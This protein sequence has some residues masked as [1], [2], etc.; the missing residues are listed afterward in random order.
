MFGYWKQQAKHWEAFV[1]RLI[2]KRDELLKDVRELR[3]ELRA[4]NVA[5][6]DSDA[7]LAAERDDNER[8]RAKLKTTQAGLD[9]ATRCYEQSEAENKKLKCMYV[10]ADNRAIDAGANIV[11]RERERDEWRETAEDSRAM[12]GRTFAA[13]ERFVRE[14]ADLKGKLNARSDHADAADRPG[15][16][17]SQHVI[18]C[19]GRGG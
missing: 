4:A 1:D 12:V 9:H 17:Q 10:D 8:L 14:L 6:A 3:D 5:T 16:S 15:R 7:Q 2:V 11:R 19:D 18:G 13:C